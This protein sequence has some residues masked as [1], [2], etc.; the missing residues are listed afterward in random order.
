M[1]HSTPAS[2]PEFRVNITNKTQ[3]HM[4]KKRLHINNTFFAISSF[5]II[6]EIVSG[7]NCGH[8]ILT[9]KSPLIAQQ[10]P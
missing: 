3:N 4:A 5:N 9:Q 6:D 10:N 8:H 1:F 7:V 2:I